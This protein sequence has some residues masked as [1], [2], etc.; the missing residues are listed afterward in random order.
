[1]VKTSLL[2]W[3]SQARCMSWRLT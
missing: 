3:R 1:M 2:F